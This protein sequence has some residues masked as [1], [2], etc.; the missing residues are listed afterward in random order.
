MTNVLVWFLFGSRPREK[1]CIKQNVIIESGKYK[2][3]SS[4]RAERKQHSESRVSFKPCFTYQTHAHNLSSI[5]IW[6]QNGSQDHWLQILRHNGYI[7]ELRGVHNGYLFT[8]MLLW[9]D[10]MA[11]AKHFRWYQRFILKVKI[12]QMQSPPLCLPTGLRN[13]HHA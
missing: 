12:P 9:R 7:W 3:Q 13:I 4:I 10:T 1:K 11:K 2:I 5:G 6:S 8:A